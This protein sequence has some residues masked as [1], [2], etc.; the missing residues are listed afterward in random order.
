MTAT[1]AETYSELF[2][3]TDI[4]GLKGIIESQTLWATHAAFLNDA[5]EIRLFGGRLPEFLKPTIADGVAYLA[6]IPTNKLLIT[7]RGGDQAVIEEIA[8]GTATGTFNA[9][10]GNQDTLPYVEPFVTSFC[11]AAT[12]QIAQHGLL[13]QWRGYA[14]NGGYAIT[15]DTAALYTL[16][17]A[18]AEKW[19]G[20]TL[21]LND[22]IYSDNEEKLRLELGS[23][24][25]EIKSSIREWMKIPPNPQSLE[26]LYFPLIQCACR[27]KHWGFSEENEVRIISIRPHKELAKMHSAYAPEAMPKPRWNFIRAGTA[28]PCIHLF[29]GITRLPDK[30]LPI[31]RI[32]VGPHRNKDER[33][34]A[35]EDLLD[36][37]HLD[38]EVSVS[39]IPYVDY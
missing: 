23:Q 21:I 1:I 24:I 20:H 39:E 13:S 17:M 18:E 22:A 27:Y 8:T 36:Q 15:F 31:T 14:K 12:K 32:I 6:R 11:T 37:Y 3:Y 5:T 38:I 4:V 10:F 25:E 7:Q 2:H 34:L 19:P 16:L 33:R 35:V 29:E 28:I 30:P 9:I 26:N